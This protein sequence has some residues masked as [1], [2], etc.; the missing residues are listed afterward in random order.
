MRQIFSSARLENVE[1]LAQILRE[2]G[3]ET[4]ITNGRSYKGGLHGNFSYI[5]QGGPMPAL[6]VVR[7]EDQTRARA[8]L[9]EAGLLP[10]TRAGTGDA[11]TLPVFRSQ[12]D[13]PG[14]DPRKKRLFRIKMAL[15]GGIV[16]VLLLT[17]LNTPQIEAPPAEPVAAVRASPPFDG[18]VSATLAPIARAVLARAISRAPALA[19]APVLCL[20]VDGHD[21]P[22]ALVASL[23]APQRAVVPQSQCVLVPDSD[24]GSYHRASGRPAMLLEVTAFRPTAPDAGTVELSAYHHRLWGDYKTLQVGI[25]DGRWQVV[26]VLKHV[27]MQ[28]V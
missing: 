28:G 18:S 10:S 23:Q 8:M 26:K 12:Q 1:T 15:L 16:V 27:S 3:I 13:E 19:S 25:V 14:S 9:R 24:R 11:H 17:L 21:A 6:W 2:A 4:R 7:A 20:S 5:E 22:A